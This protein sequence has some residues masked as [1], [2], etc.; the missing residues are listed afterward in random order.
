MKLYDITQPLEPGLAVWPGDQPYE[1]LWSAR[2]IEGSSVNIGQFRMSTHAGTHADAPLHVKDGAASMDKL[3]LLQFVGPCTVVK[4]K[5][6]EAIIQPKHL[7]SYAEGDL[8]ARVLF[9]TRCSARSHRAWNDDFPALAPELIPWL[10]MRGVCL[11]GTD[12]PSVDPADS[13]SLPTHHALRTH[14]MVALENLALED[15]P[16]G[17]YFLCAL[18]LKLV[19]MDAAPVRAVLLEEPEGLGG[20]KPG[21]L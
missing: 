17:H 19:G 15:V 9:K 3:P 10:S 21:V 4:V 20:E 5:G 18:P 14:G 13:T 1:S 2:I 12:A 11:V 7:S 8:N 16:P 6:G